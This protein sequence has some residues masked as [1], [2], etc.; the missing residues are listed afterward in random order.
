MIMQVTVILYDDPTPEE[1][2]SAKMVA[3]IDG[4][5][6]VEMEPFVELDVVVEGPD[7]TFPLAR[8]RG[9]V[10][11]GVAQLLDQAHAEVNKLGRGGRESGLIR[12]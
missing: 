1:V 8:I 12:P 10:M 3:S 7:P 5:E 11:N 9:N 6:P 2:E 4:V